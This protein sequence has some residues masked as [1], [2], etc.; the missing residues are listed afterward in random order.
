M[1]T[2][3]SWTKYQREFI[4]SLVFFMLHSFLYTPLDLNI[5]IFLLSYFCCN[6]RYILLLFLF[7]LRMNR[8]FCHSRFLVLV[9]RRSFPLGSYLGNCPFLTLIGLFLQLQA[10]MCIVLFDMP[11]LGLNERSF[12]LYLFQLFLLLFIR[13]LVLVLVLVVLIFRNL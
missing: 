12:L 1:V 6:I 3:E 9:F 11:I 7:I 2:P 4:F 8:I 13:L 10:L 5:L